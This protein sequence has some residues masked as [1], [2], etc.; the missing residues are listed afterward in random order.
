MQKEILTEKIPIKMWL[1]DPE[2]GSL[3]QARNLA[4]LPLLLAIS[5]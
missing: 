1:N 4:N 2:E 5:A 3:A